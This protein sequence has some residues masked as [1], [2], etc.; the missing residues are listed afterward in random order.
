[1]LHSLHI[2]YNNNNN[3]INIIIILYIH[4]NSDTIERYQ[5]RVKDMLQQVRWNVNIVE[6]I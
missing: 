3:N 2:I 4:I 5:L 1:M 6:V